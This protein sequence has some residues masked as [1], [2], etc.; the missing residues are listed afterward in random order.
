M[1]AMAMRTEPGLLRRFALAAGLLLAATAA[2]A[3]ADAPARPGV[4]Y[5][6]PP[7]DEPDIDQAEPGPP[8]RAPEPSR[9]RTG[10]RI[11]IE[12]Y[13]EIAQI[14]SAELDGGD[15]FT[16]TS[17]AA[18]VDGRIQTRRVRAQASYRYQRNIDWSG[19]DSDNHSGIAVLNADIVPGVLQFD[20]GGLAA[21]TGFGRGVSGLTS[22]DA[23]SD[24]YSLYAGPTLATHVGPLSLN[25][26]YRFGYVSVD[27]DASSSPFRLGFGDQTAHNL[28]ASIGMG[29]GGRLPFGWTIGGG[30]ARTD[31]DGP[32]DDRF[33]GAYVRGDVVVPVGPTLALTAGLG[34]EDLRASQRDLL[35]DVNGNA[36][37]GPGGVPVADPSRPRLLTYDIDG[38]IYDGGL[39]WRPSPRTEL[40]ARAGRRYGGTTVVATLQHNMGRGYGLGAAV[41][42][43][44]QT[45]GGTIVNDLS[46]LP[47]EF[48]VTRNPF[49]GNLSGCAFGNEGGQGLC[50]DPALQSIRSNSFRAR[51]ASV[52]FS[53]ERGL[54]SFGLGASYIHRRYNQPDDPAFDIIGDSDDSIGLYGNVGRQLS[55]SS[56]LNFDAYATWF[57]SDAPGFDRNVGIGGTATYTRSFLLDRL[58]LL[59]ALGLYHNDGGFADSTI[60]S[61]LVGLRYTF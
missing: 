52:L 41:F 32:F 9:R 21:R 18:G 13:V 44:V 3:Q 1:T 40:Q 5:D 22:R 59:A 58:R 15:T 33:R 14:L 29:T 61:G 37:L 55:R 17:L 23:S 43:T 34:Y 35:R 12:P 46:G 16:Y 31:S 49:T 25:A 4:S 56:E 30:Y 28:T 51:G 57:D 50:F 7:L 6:L 8:A 45:F 24:L 54:W 36:I 42:D 19:P 20:A 27:D 10:P 39:I 53:G 11:D 26:A 48:D 60:L 38:L 47:T 2:G